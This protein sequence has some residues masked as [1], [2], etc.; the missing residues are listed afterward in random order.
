MKCVVVTQIV[1]ALQL[2][3]K[4]VMKGKIKESL[5][6]LSSEQQFCESDTVNYCT[7][8]HNWIL[9]GLA[10]RRTT[11]KCEDFK[12]H[13]ISRHFVSFKRENHNTKVQCL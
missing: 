10:G 9:Q 1:H 13:C 5:W 2:I 6:K 12:I 3:E 8:V 4:K 7:H 11:S